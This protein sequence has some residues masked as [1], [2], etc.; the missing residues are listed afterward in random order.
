MN[1]YRKLAADLLVGDY[2]RVVSHVPNEDQRPECFRRVEK[3]EYIE[4]L[5]TSS[6]PTASS[7]CS[8]AGFLPGQALSLSGATGS[9]RRSSTR[10]A[11]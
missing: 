2:L 8:A 7:P 5:P 11:T 6:S 4:A 1:V 9:A 3:I 10:P